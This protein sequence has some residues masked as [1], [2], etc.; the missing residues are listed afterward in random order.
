MCCYSYRAIWAFEERDSQFCMAST[1]ALVLSQGVLLT[2]GVAA[3]QLC[4]CI[5]EVSSG[6]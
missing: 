3:L 4:P 1:S 5:Q 6:L 2:E